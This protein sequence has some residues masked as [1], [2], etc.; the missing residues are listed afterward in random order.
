MP[1]Q[2]RI[3]SPSFQPFLVA[4]SE[5]DVF[6]LTCIVTISSCSFCVQGFEPSWDYKILA[7]QHVYHYWWATTHFA[8]S[9]KCLL[10]RCDRTPHLDWWRVSGLK[11]PTTIEGHIDEDVGLLGQQVG[12]FILFHHLFLSFVFVL[13]FKNVGLYVCKHISSKFHILWLKSISV[14]SI[15]F[16]VCNWMYE[17]P[18]CQFVFP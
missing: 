11:L 1:V 12:V 5:L 13:F 18:K 16:Q 7:C 6:D 2:R 8:C 17:L 10:R 3:P 9:L 15:A 14:S 4:F